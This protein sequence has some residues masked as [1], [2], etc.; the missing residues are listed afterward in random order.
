MEELYEAIEQHPVTLFGLILPCLGFFGGITNK[1]N[2]SW[3]DS[4]AFGF[5]CWFIMAVLVWTPILITTYIRLKKTRQ[6]KAKEE[7]SENPLVAFMEHR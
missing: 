1:G 7:E 4:I 2:T 6:K 5:I 3:T